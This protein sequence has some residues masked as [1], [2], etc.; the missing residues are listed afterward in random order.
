M[1]FCGLESDVFFGD[2]Q[3]QLDGLPNVPQGFFAGFALAPATW[4]GGTTDG[5]AFIRFYQ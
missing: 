5:K 4:Q 2:L 1:A 3:L